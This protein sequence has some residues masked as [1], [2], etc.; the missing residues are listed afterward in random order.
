MGGELA[1]RLEVLWAMFLHQEQRWDLIGMLALQHEGRVVALDLERA[2]AGAT[3]IE[4]RLPSRKAACPCCSCQVSKATTAGS[5]EVAVFMVL[6]SYA[7]GPGSG[8]VVDGRANGLLD[9]AKAGEVLCDLGL[10]G[11]AFD[12]FEQIGLELKRVDAGPPRLEPGLGTGDQL[13]VVAV[14]RLAVAA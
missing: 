7:A 12:V 2:V 4:D 8:G 3:A 13:A 1:Q 9:T 10:D 6:M 5:V 11:I 14:F